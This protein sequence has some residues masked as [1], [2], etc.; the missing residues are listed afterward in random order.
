MVSIAAWCGL[1]T[2][3]LITPFV[4]LSSA[5]FA[6]NEASLV[7][8]NCS[9]EKSPPCYFLPAAAPLPIRRQVLPSRVQI[10]SHPAHTPLSIVSI[11]AIPNYHHVK[12]N[13]NE[14]AGLDAT[15][16]LLKWDTAKVRTERKACTVPLRHPMTADCYSGCECTVHRLAF[17]RDGRAA[18]SSTAEQHYTAY[19]SIPCPIM[20]LRFGRTAAVG[21]QPPSLT[22]TALVHPETHLPSPAAQPTLQHSYTL[23][24]CIPSPRRAVSWPGLVVGQRRKDTR[25]LCSASSPRLASR[26]HAIDAL[27]VVRSFAA[28]PL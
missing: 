22:L 10:R 3:S 5:A 23:V 16:T 17:G 18:S 24:D 19:N 11:A 15:A 14:A 12:H 4:T 1:R 20:K 7:W 6:S 9:I 26:M 28:E 27:F 8:T 2:P 21:H 13:A 25:A